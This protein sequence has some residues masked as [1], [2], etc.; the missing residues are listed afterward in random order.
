MIK[1]AKWAII[2]EDHYGCPMDIEWAK[3]GKD[4][5]FIVQARPETVVSQKK[6]VH[7]LRNYHLKGGDQAKVLASGAA[8]GSKVGSGTAQVI[9]EIKDIASFEEGNVL[10]TDQT[11]PDWEPILKKARAVV[12][13]R[14]GRTC[15]AAIISRELG[16]PCIVGCETATMHVPDGAKVTVDTS[17]GEKG[18]VLEGIIPFEIEEINLQSIPSTKTKICLL[19]GNPEAA[20]SHSF[21]PN[22]GVGLARME[23]IISSSIKVHPLALL[24]PDKLDRSDQREILHVIGGGNRQLTAELGKQHFIDKLSEGVA[25]ISAGFWPK[26]VILRFSDFKSDE[27]ANLLGGKQFEPVEDNPMIGWRG[28]SRYYDPNYREGFALECAAIRRVRE[29]L[30]LSNLQVMIPFVRTV[31]ELKSV[32]EEMKKNGLERGKE[33]LTVVM[34]CELPSNAVLADEFLEHIDGFSIGSN[35]LTQLTLG[36]D[37]NSATVARLYDER[38]PAV[39]SLISTAIRASNKKQ[40]YIGI[41][42][43]APSDYPEFCEF[44]VEENIGSISVQPDRI[45]QTRLLVAEKEKEKK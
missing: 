14:G 7:I 27:Y 30:G 41:C 34:M 10:I 8:V 4:E 19:L 45:I 29:E 38:N 9:H 43:Q 2:I 16:I 35:D 21:L 13:N 39:K 28:A 5:L 40:K 6:D 3:N 20:F 26:P 32:L 15:H 1:L 18:R 31:D 33:G 44:L 37:R 22:D 25:L 23:F 17:T 36:L 24:N 11:D 12:T 42:G